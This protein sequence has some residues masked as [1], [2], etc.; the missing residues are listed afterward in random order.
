MAN[1]VSLLP[2]ALLIFSSAAYAQHEGH[3][4]PQ[5]QQAPPAQQPE[6]QAPQPQKPTPSPP[7]RP[8][9]QPTKA[10]TQAQPD[11]HRGHDTPPPTATPPPDR[12]D[13]VGHGTQQP[14]IPPPPP[15]AR[16][17]APRPLPALE[18]RLKKQLAVG[19][20]Y[21]REELQKIALE[22]NPTLAQ[23]ESE[24]RAAS[25][26]RRQAGLWP[27]PSLGYT[28]EEIRGGSFGGGQQ[29]FFVEQDVILGRKLRQ[30]QRVFEQEQRIAE[31]ELEEQRLRVTIAVQLA[32][33]QILASQELLQV[34]EDLGRLSAENYA[35]AARL[36]NVGSL[37]DTEVL[38]ARIEAQRARLAILQQENQLRRDW[39]SLAAVVG[40]PDLRTGWIEGN[41]EENLPTLSEA[42]IIE[43]I[44]ARSPAVRI[45][46]ISVERSRAILGLAR[47]QPIP[48]LRFRGGLQQNRELLEGTNRRVGMQGFAEV[49][50][51][52]PIF[53][54]NQGNIVAAEAQVSRSTREFDRVR[55]LLRERAAASV[56]T[57]RNAADMVE[58]Y[59]SGILPDAREAYQL[60]IRSWGQMAASYPQLLLAQRTLVEVNEEYVT[61]LQELWRTSIALQGF[62]LTDGLEAPARPDEVEMPVRELNIPMNRAGGDRRE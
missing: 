59:R 17:V 1:R 56:Q 9:A 33:F 4:A 24:I 6:A 42:E 32:Y 61:S 35:T 52:L 41:I 55:L 10:P 18:S 20:R 54:R 39:V 62:L 60:M 31:I 27:N 44:V 34:R 11:P 37:D 8:G 38:Q 36:R 49:G 12:G 47:R 7:A 22:S 15:Q 14:G 13:H 2:L 25:G 45:A 58:Q 19:V 40:K 3:G 50:I 43:S 46:D 51:S 48:D 23:A 5:Q 21:T 53:N 57:Y 30:G 26:R 29:G 28:G 16:G